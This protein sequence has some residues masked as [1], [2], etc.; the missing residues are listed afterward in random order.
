M[1]YLLSFFSAFLLSG[2][3]T[4]LL[5][6]FGKKR[7]ILAIPRE[8]DVHKDP[9]P[10]L[11][12]LGIFGG[13]LLV[14]LFV[15]L[16][17]NTSLRFTHSL[18]FGLDSH[19]WGIWLGGVVIVL[20]MLVDD[21]VGLSTWKKLI[22][23]IVVTILVIACGIGIESLSNPFGGTINLNSVYVTLFNSG[24]IHYSFSLWSD[25]LTLVW[26]V[27]MMNVMNFV[28]GVDGLAGGQAAIAAFTIFLLSISIAV[29]QPATA[30]VAIILCGAALGFLVWNFPPAKIFM[31]DSGSMFLGF[32]LGVLALISGGKLATILLVLGFPI[33]DGLIVV[34]SRLA[35]RKNPFTTPDKTHMHHRFLNAG[36]TPRQAVLS[37]YLI[38]G[39]F[40]WIALSS[41][42]KGKAVGFVA[43]VFLVLLVMAW[44]K[45]I[46]RKRK[47]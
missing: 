45:L 37:L 46:E 41:S 10:R 26:L 38:S 34:A 11:G 8:R 2:L 3:F 19:L 23:Q 27:G 17:T 7:G 32:I 1:N 9:I 22:A 43:L 15:F 42:S 4:G 13:F 28:D 24:G 36:F 25:L 18:I 5:W 33:V 44:L 29:N 14:S 39:L 40:G 16:V 35:R 20:V 12:G 30:M 47:S 21:L 6:H 31:G